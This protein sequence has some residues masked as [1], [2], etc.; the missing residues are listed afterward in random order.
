MTDTSPQG[1]RESLT[2]LVRAIGYLIYG[3]VIVVEIILAVGFVLK[4][5]G[6][7][8]SAG[9]VEW[10]YRGLDRVM[11]PFRGIFTPLDLGTTG[12][13]VEAVL[14][15][16]ILFAMVIYAV[17]MLFVRGAIDWMSHRLEL[18]RHDREMALRQR[19][20]DEAERRRAIAEAARRRADA[21]RAAQ[22]GGAAGAAAVTQAGSIPPAPG[23]VPPGTPPPAPPPPPS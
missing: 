4:L 3:Y 12:N 22:V 19:E 20:L 9:F 5:F 14:D 1:A 2:W 23:V 7:N 6:A 15:T 21:E 13:E 8:P 10:W 16:S 11:A 17:V 18:Q